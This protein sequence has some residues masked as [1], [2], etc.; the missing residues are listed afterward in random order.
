MLV[1]NKQDH[2]QYNGLRIVLFYHKVIII[3]GTNL[4]Y[5]VG[6]KVKTDKEWKIEPKIQFG[7]LTNLKKQMDILQ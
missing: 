6:K 1:G 4:V 3:R 2:Q 5:M 7:N